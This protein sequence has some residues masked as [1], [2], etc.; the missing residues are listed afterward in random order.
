MTEPLPT[1]RRDA[2]FA[3]APGAVAALL[4][5]ALAQVAGEGVFPVS[6]TLDYANA[7]R[8]GEAVVVEAWV[9]R[10]TRSLVFVH[11]KLGRSGDGALLAQAAAVFRR[12]MDAAPRA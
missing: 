12:G 10:A 7:G 6:L 1:L 4:E 3:G 2:L 11:G 9:E 8:P 5:P